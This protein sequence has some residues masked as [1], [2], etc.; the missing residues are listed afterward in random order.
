MAKTNKV[1]VS[2]S[3]PNAGSSVIVLSLLGALSKRVGRIG[4]FKPVSRGKENTDATLMKAVYGLEPSTSQM[5]PLSIAESRQLMARDE[6]GK[7]LDRICAAYDVIRGTSDLVVLEGINYQRSISAFDMDINAAVAARLGAPVVLVAGASSPKGPVSPEELTTSVISAWSSFQEKGC[8][9][10]GVVVNRVSRDSST[11]DG[12]EYVKA[13]E[14]ENITVL[15]AVPD[16]AYLAMPRLAQIVEGL[17]AEVLSGGAFLENIVTKTLVAAMEPRNFV[18][19][20]RYDHT[21]V[22]CPGD[23]EDTVLA[24]ALTQKSRQH[25]R[26]SGLVLTGGLRPDQ[27]ILDLVGANGDSEFPILSVEKDTYDTVSAIRGL[28]VRIGPDDKDKIYTACS[29]VEHYV[30]QSKLWEKLEFSKSQ[31][32]NAGSFLERIVS[33]AKER[34]K[35]IVFPEGEESRTIRAV[36]RLAQGKVLQPV[37]L[38]NPD[39]INACAKSEGVS[40]EGVGIEDPF[41]SDQR[42]RYGELVHEL[43]KHKRGGM[44]METALQWVDSSPINYGVAM[45]HCGAADGLVA[46]AIHST[47]DTIRPAFQIIGVRPDVGIAS[48]V[49]LMVFKNRVLAYGDCAIIPNPN[50]QEL[51]SIAIA[52]AHTA[53]TFGID[54]RVAMLSY[55]TGNSGSGSDVDKVAEATRIVKEREPFLFID[56][57]MQY[58]TAIDPEVAKSKQPDSPV[59]GRATVFIFPTLDAGNIAYKAVQRMSGALAVGPIMQGM[60]KPVNDLSR[61]CSVDDIYYVGAITAVQANGK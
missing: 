44:T 61:G 32:A 26:I 10:V 48:S 59:A 14:K 20:L 23:R 24:L 29:A 17:S 19:W 13:L 54:P 27:A 4:F 60:K 30:D 55:S 46:G 35:T 21:L 53:R 8:D 57:P 47:G 58:D 25:R 12:E 28:S 33:K 40:L 22:V 16:L 5:C 15:G 45:V 43:R 49:F 38:G 56:G 37:L 1:Y 2:A 3:D 42:E 18:K 7:M 6:E 39:K 36:S 11:A 9:L 31:P 41:A 51:A 34:N 50:A 52:G